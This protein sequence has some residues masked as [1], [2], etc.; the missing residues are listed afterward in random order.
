MAVITID[1]SGKIEKTNVDT[2]VA[3]AG[4]KPFVVLLPSG[5]KRRLAE[6]VKR[7]N[8]GKLSR[9]PTLRLFTACVFLSLE[10]LSANDL[11][12]IDYEYTGRHSEAFI[13]SRLLEYI[14]K[15]YHA[16]EKEQISFGKIGKDTEAHRL[17]NETF[18]RRRKPDKVITENEL[19]GLI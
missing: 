3:A 7:R 13:R 9:Y 18:R 6:T 1:Q 2:V 16:F 12:I 10:R 14:K 11:V 17:A 15:R 4:V 19:I 5:I 8:I